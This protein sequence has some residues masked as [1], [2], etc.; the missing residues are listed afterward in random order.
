M[1]TCSKVIAHSAQNYLTKHN[2]ED[3][4]QSWLDREGA[5]CFRGACERC[6][7]L[8]ATFEQEI[9]LGGRRVQSELHRFLA[10]R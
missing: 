6:I 3:Y 2:I 1:C 4:L 10:T 8:G 7:E 9:L 5:E